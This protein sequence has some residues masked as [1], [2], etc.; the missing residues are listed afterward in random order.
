[1]RA[2]AVAQHDRGDRADRGQAF[3]LEELQG[4]GELHIV[5]DA[6][7]FEAGV[8]YSPFPFVVLSAGW[9]KFDLNFTDKATGSG[10][11]TSASGPVF[12]AGVKW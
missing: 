9:R 12:Q 11:N 10:R 4:G 3:A 6:L 5:L 7:E 8:G 1:M 2:G